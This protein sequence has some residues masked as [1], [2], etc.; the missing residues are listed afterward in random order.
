MSAIVVYFCCMNLSKN[1]Q[2]T[3]HNL[4]KPSEVFTLIE[5]L[6]VVAIIG[7]GS[8]IIMTS[9]NNSKAKGRDSKSNSRH[10]RHPARS[11]KGIMT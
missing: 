10:K 9:V 3:T 2:P 8:G 1:L 5:L 7:T 11:L 6:V 4:K